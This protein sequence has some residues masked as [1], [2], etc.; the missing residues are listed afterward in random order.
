MGFQTVEVLREVEGRAVASL[1]EVFSAVSTDSRTVRAGELFVALPG[2][3]HD[4]HAFVADALRRG[5]GAALVGEGFEGSPGDALVRVRDTREALLR[6]GLHA[7]RRWGG[8]SW[9]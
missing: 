3:R 7:R 8:P 9:P 5:A 4:G 1:P 2:A 6:L